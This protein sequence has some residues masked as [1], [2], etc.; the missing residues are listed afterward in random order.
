MLSANVNHQLYP[1][2]EC[3]LHKGHTNLCFSEASRR[4]TDLKG[5]FSSGGE[6]NGM[7]HK[8]LVASAGVVGG[9]EAAIIPPAQSTLQSK[10][11]Y[12]LF[13]KKYIE[14]SERFGALFQ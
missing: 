10:S 2:S 7:P 6:N 13:L 8:L 11:Y 12:Q 4:T 3:D 14:L 5:S 9:V 1:F